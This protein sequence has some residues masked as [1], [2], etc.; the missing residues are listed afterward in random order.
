MAYRPIPFV[1]GE[2]FHLVNRGNL[3]CDIFKDNV[4]RARFLF[5]LL[6]FQSAESFDQINRYVQKFLKTGSFGFNEKE[7]KKITK[8]HLVK[9]IAFSLMPNH[10]HVLVQSSIDNGVSLYM[11]RVLNAYTKY[12]NTKYQQTGHLFQGPFRAVHVEDNEQLLYTSAYVHLNPIE[13]IRAGNVQHPMLD[14][15]KF[16]WSSFNDFVGQNR[17]GK[18]L[19]PSIILDQ[20]EGKELKEKGQDYQK[21]V[22]G[23]GAK[24]LDIAT[25]YL[26][27]E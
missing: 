7:I 9:V 13:L 8:K 15:L 1:A 5:C 2:Y 18:L 24:E 26:S 12:F 14:T 19:D 10:F 6:C 22:E 17:W 3:H 11:Q 16:R 25:D 27:L 20:M 21:W 23:S 4:D